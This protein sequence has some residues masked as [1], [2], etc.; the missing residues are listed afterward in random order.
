MVPLGRQEEQDLGL[1]GPSSLGL[2][3]VTLTECQSGGQS[4]LLV[5][6]PN[7]LCLR[8]AGHHH[9]ASHQSARALLLH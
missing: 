3:L 6:A 5:T 7:W 8:C 2:L 4:C 1:A 9:T